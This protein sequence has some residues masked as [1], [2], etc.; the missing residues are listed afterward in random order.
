M[1][2]PVSVKDFNDFL[3]ELIE[4]ALSPKMPLTMPMLKVEPDKSVGTPRKMAWTLATRLQ[5]K[6]HSYIRYRSSVAGYDLNTEKCL[7]RE[8]EINEFRNIL[9][10]MRNIL[11]EYE[12]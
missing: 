7:D 2:N 6:M 12:V 8:Q 1:S 4:A 3:D 5:V 10:E 9:I 11:W